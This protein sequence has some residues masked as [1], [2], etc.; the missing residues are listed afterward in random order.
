MP[1][2]KITVDAAMRARDVSRPHADQERSAY[3]AQ[4]D[5]V[6]AAEDS[7]SARRRKPRQPP[8]A[9]GPRARRS[10]RG[11]GGGGG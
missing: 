3:A 9:P 2:M 4:A 11:S 1:V 7:P 10:R 6:G 8:A 5:P